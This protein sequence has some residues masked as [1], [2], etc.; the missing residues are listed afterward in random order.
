MSL[1]YDLFFD[2]TLRNVALGTLLLGLG[3]GA[4]GSFM[5][6]RGESLIGDAIAHAT[7]P[8]VVLAYLL[9]STKDPLLLLSGAAIAGI[10]GIGA[11]MGLTRTTKIDSDGANGI[12][13]S[14]FFGFGLL[15][16]TYIQKLPDASQAGLDRFIFGQAA[17]IV[18]SDVALI[19]IVQGVV[20]LT[21]ILFFK[22]LK[23]STFDPQSTT[24]M[25]FNR[26]IIDAI[27]ATLLVAVIVTGL[28]TVGVILISALLVTPA[29]AARQ[30]THSLKTMVILSSLF[31]GISGMV[32]SLISATEMNLPTGPIIVLVL[33]AIVVIS[34][35]FGSRRGLVIKKVSQYRR[36]GHFDE[37]RIL[38]ALDELSRSHDQRG[39]YHSHHTISLLV[40][41]RHSMR[42]LL[43]KLVKEGAIL[44]E[45][46]AYLLSKQGEAT[47]ASLAL[48]EVHHDR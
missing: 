2:Y 11:I 32:G 31:S 43:A 28:Q 13:L 3:S 46:D 30:W 41:E 34:L 37:R 7:L 47:V 22:E 38:L 27:F 4:I 18:A 26:K 48:E 40:G 20:L 42:R 12:I 10:L 15:L 29:A 39:L 16:L 36:Q 35:L 25:G 23:S 19:A 8:G 6:L 44:K 14:I 33:T 5:T 24:V 21:L 45:G 17:T 1:L 9:T